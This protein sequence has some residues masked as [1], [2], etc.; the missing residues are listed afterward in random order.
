M[1]E[2][3]VGGP[4]LAD[5]MQ[6]ADGVDSGVMSGTTGDAAGADDALPFLPVVAYCTG[7]LAAGEV[8]PLIL[9]TTG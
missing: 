4:E 6:A 3:A 5:A 9:S 8:T 7:K 1:G 2:I